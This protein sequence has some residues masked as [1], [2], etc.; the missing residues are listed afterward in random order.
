MTIE[1][2]LDLGVTGGLLAILIAGHRKLWVWGWLY[3]ERVQERDF[4]RGLA[5]RGT[6][7]AERATNVAVEAHPDAQ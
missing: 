3:A 6:D 4:W 7:L 5:L 1:Q 2:L